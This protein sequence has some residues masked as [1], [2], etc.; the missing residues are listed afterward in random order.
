MATFVVS[1]F[2]GERTIV[3]IFLTH[4]LF[5]LSKSLYYESLGL[6][7]LAFTGD[8]FGILLGEVTLPSVMLSRLIQL[9][10]AV[11]SK[12]IGPQ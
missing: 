4:I 1:L 5:C 9:S 6:C 3:V 11:E 12:D 10:R 2:N 8:S 7:L